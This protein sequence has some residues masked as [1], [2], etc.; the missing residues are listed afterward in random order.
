VQDKLPQLNLGELFFFDHAVKNYDENGI[1]YDWWKNTGKKIDYDKEFSLRSQILE[2]YQNRNIPISIKI[3]QFGSIYKLYP[4][5]RKFFN[6]YVILKRKNLE[7]SFWSLILALH[8]CTW[9]TVPSSNVTITVEK[10]KL[11]L[12]IR[13]M[14][15]FIQIQNK[16]ENDFFANVVYYEDILESSLDT[17]S[18]SECNKFFKINSKE[19]TIIS[20]LYE[21]NLWLEEYQ[22][23][24]LLNIW[25]DFQFSSV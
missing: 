14:R 7:L 16:L 23:Q 21:V 4:E 20:N 12:S 5:L 3:N 9:R 17:H 6:S 10:T 15:D 19:K 18:N 25:L 2:F 1:S 8:T 22:F 11:E 24:K 13:V